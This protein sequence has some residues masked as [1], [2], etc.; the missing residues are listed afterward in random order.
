[1]GMHVRGVEGRDQYA[2]L[3][4]F[5]SP[6]SITQTFNKYLPMNEG[7]VGEKEKTDWLDVE[8]GVGRGN[9]EQYPIS[10]RLMRWVRV[11]GQSC[12]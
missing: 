11:G 12:H 3:P 9:Q 2:T 5:S 6:G 7:H 8:G 4:C 10:G 1:M